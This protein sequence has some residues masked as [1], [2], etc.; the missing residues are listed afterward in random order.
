MTDA[1]D[2]SDTSGSRVQAAVLIVG[3]LIALV[4][5]GHV[6]VVATSG[7]AQEYAENASA[8]CDQELGE[9]DYVLVNSRVIGGHGGLHCK[10]S[11][12]E[13]IHL[14]DVPRSEIDAAAAE[15]S[16]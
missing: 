5:A 11:N 15:V 12:G 10:G 13:F 1:N 3:V 14:H 9:D 6:A 2:G 16:E 8:Y 4:V 7:N